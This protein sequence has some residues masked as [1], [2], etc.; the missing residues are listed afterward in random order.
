[1]ERFD[2]TC[3]C[4]ASVLSGTRRPE[5]VVV[6]VD[7]NPILRDRLRESLPTTVQVIE[8]VGS[9]AA[10][11]RNTALRAATGAVALF[12]DDDA[13][14]EPEWLSELHKAFQDPSLV[15]AGG[16]VVPEWEDPDAA[17]PEELFWIVGSTYR[18]HRTD[19][20]PIS[21]PIGAN[22][23]ARREALLEL[24]GFPS[25]FG[26]R[27]GTKVS[28]N[29]E[30]ATFTA[31]TN[32]FGD[33]SVQYV[34]TAV[35]HHFAPAAR[36]TPRYVIG[37][38]LVE[39]TSKADVRRM[40]G[41]DVMDADRA[42][43]RDVIGS[44]ILAY[45]MEG[46]RKRNRRS[47]RFAGFVAGSF[48]LTAGAY[49]TRLARSTATEVVVPALKATSRSSEGPD[50]V[51]DPVRSEKFSA[52]SGSLRVAM[53]TAR[54]LPF[55]GGIETHVDEVARRLARRGIALTVLSTDVTGKLP[56]VEEK[57]GVVTKRFPA[58]PKSKDYYVSPRLLQA[59]AK[60]SFDVIHVQ[61][62]HNAVPPLALA[63]AERHHIP[64]L[65]TFHTGGN[66]SP[67]RNAIRGIQWRV[68]GP[69][70]RRA[71]RLVAVCEFEADL[72]AEALNVDRSKIALVRNG[73]ER[74][75][76]GDRA[77]EIT[78]A[79]LILSIGRLERYKGHH[80]AIGAMP[81]VLRRAPGARLA[82]VGH[83]PYETALREQVDQLGLSESV[84][85]VSYGPDDRDLMGALV[86]SANVAV[87]LSEYEAHPVAVMEAL[88]EGVDVVVAATSGMT[89]LGRDGLVTT[90]ALDSSGEELADVLLKVADEHRW[91][92]GAPALPSWDDCADA[93]AALYREV[94][95][96]E[97]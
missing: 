56:K 60:G 18:G 32:H 94:A 53:V 3:H 27:A 82:I 8:N 73:S 38:S 13:W 92:S 21:R 17:L 29:E 23:A 16:R 78:G 37:R 85:F 5:E 34:P 26:P 90:V 54:S 68:E 50:A 93:L 6:V 58:W 2:Q 11:A 15:G 65:I 96:C 83:G 80:R 28:S 74:L 49:V 91:S 41:S 81:A 66:S 52:A 67:F 77:P 86:R 35:V 62:V 84:S 57:D 1:M 64:C 31:I 22:M 75:P 69:L 61:G 51:I 43:V 89:E 40:F 45:L 44:G 20:G 9:G 87:L 7:R 14:G 36:C 95:T 79:P 4:V 63:V 24:G 46:V 39:G 10:D 33:Q 97:S 47:L 25:A 76:V 88:A 70:L 30:L 42:Y 72:F 55:M 59:L 12:I 48:L 19:A 71:T